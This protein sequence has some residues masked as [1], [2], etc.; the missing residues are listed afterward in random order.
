[1]AILTPSHP[2]I[3]HS[4]CM[5]RVPVFTGFE[6]WEE[7]RRRP[8]EGF[9]VH[10]LSFCSFQSTTVSFSQMTRLHKAVWK[11]FQHKCISNAGMAV[12]SLDFECIFKIE[13]DFWYLQIAA[14]CRII[15]IVPHAGRHI[16]QHPEAVR[17][18]HRVLRSYLC[19][20][21]VW[22]ERRDW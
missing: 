14:G 9:V 4:M 6:V 7:K 22:E 2:C 12:P 18:T 11:H 8:W 16:I 19:S 5:M 15:Y 10:N 3:I 17:A 20:W 21:H 1:M 13:T